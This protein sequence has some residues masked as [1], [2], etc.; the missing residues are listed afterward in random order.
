MSVSSSSDQTLY[1]ASILKNINLK[2]FNLDYLPI[3]SDRKKLERFLGLLDS[4]AEDK[5]S[6][7]RTTSE[8]PAP[9]AISKA[10]ITNRILNSARA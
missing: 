6:C 3:R 2:R 8:D 1:Y 5:V 4:L 9:R 10:E 7:Y